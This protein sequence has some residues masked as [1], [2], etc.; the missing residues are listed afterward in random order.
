MG[1][2][3]ELLLLPKDVSWIFLYMTPFSDEC[4]WGGAAPAEGWVLDFSLYASFLWSVYLRSCCSRRSMDP[5]FLLYASFL[6]WVY[7]RI[8]C[9]CRRMDPEFSSICILYLTGVPEE[10]LLLPKDGPWILLYVHPFS[11]GC[12][13][14]AAALSEWWTLGSPL[15]ASFSDGCTWR[16]TALAE[17]WTLGFPIN[18]CYLWWLYL[19]SCCSCR[20]RGTAWPCCRRR[21][22][23]CSAQSPLSFRRTQRCSLSTNN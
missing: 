2:P 11:N 23:R 3:E 22:R 1:V 14:G 20:S 5:G 13:W 19:R 6:W 18:A 10:L 17:G 12:T 4:T 16:T 8:I 15:N 21:S 7:L 9:S